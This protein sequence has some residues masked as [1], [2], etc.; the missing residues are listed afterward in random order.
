MKF[1]DL[2]TDEK[3]LLF[4]GASLTILS[5]LVL[6]FFITLSVV[7]LVTWSVPHFW[8]LCFLLCAVSLGGWMLLYTGQLRIGGGV[9]VRRNNVLLLF[10]LILVVLISAVVSFA[11]YQKY[12][13]ILAL[14]LALAAFHIA[15][16]GIT[17]PRM[18]LWL[19][20]NEPIVR[21]GAKS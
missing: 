19:L 6:L 21:D 13:A 2:K 9:S 17:S 20:K 8:N 15:V 7:S 11:G 16:P 4:V 10:S 5:F 12:I 18:L 3:L 14:V 1:H